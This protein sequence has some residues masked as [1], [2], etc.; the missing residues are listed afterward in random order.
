MNRFAGHFYYN[1]ESLG[2]KSIVLTN[3][4]ENK[5][6]YQMSNLNNLEN[7]KNIIDQYFGQNISTFDVTSNASN[8]VIGALNNSQFSQFQLCF[9]KRLERLNRI[10]TKNDNNRKQVIDTLNL[11]ANE[12]NWEGAYAEITGYDFFNSGKGSLSLPIE[13][14]K[15]VDAKETLANELGKA[16]ANFDGYFKDFDIYFDIKILSDKIKDILD[17]IYKEIK[18]SF[19]CKK[20]TIEPEYPLD[21]PYEDFQKNRRK[22]LDEL[23]AKIDVNKKTSNVK[24]DVIEYLSH[25]VL[26]GKGIISTT[27]T[28][29]PYWHAMN[30]HKLLFQHMKKFSINNPSLIVFVFFPW[31]SEK[32][33]GLDGFNKIF[34]RSFARRFFCQY[35]HNKMKAVEIT[36]KY[37]NKST[38]VYEVTK[39]LSGVIFLEDESINA[40]N[41]SDINARAYVYLNPNADKKVGQGIFQD[42][43]MSINVEE[44][45]GFDFDNY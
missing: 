21:L 3:D 15:T 18:K 44:I 30:H 14:D 38:L 13:I 6:R 8:K 5:E 11:I 32:I 2:L 35:K 37:K 31:F 40:T 36:K 24:S 43:L 7:Y 4:S 41:P 16:N 12:K 20:L 29:N 1:A 17:G 42:Y 10:Y 9:K 26:W 27:S 39:K 23:K 25:R 33:D 45:D 34:Y 19:P 22:L 28:Y